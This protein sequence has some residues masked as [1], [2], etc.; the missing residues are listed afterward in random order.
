[1]TD[2]KEISNTRTCLLCSTSIDSKQK[3]Y[4][5]LNN[6]V[7]TCK[8]CRIEFTQKCQGRVR[9]YCSKSCQANDPKSIKTANKKRMD[10]GYLSENAKNTTKKIKEKY[11][12]DNISQLDSVKKKKASKGAIG[13]ARPEYNELIKNR[14]GVDNIS[15]LNEIKEKKR[16]KSLDKY[17]VDNVSKA[18][19]IIK[20]IETT[21]LKNY[22]V[23]TV[24][25]LP[26]N[27]LKSSEKNRYRISKI[28]RKWK[29]ELLNKFDV[30]FDFEQK[31]G[32][33]FLTDL[34]FENLRIDVNPSISHSNT[35]SY[36]HAAGI[37]TNAECSKKSHKP[38][39]R[40]YHQKR[41][42]DAEKN[43]LILL[44]Y[45]DWYDKN[46]FMNIVESKLKKTPERIYARK[47]VLKEIKQSEANRFFKENHLL[48]GSNGQSLCLGLFYGDELVHCQTYG[49]SR[50]NKSYEWEAIRSCSKLNTQI[51]GGFSKCDKY[52]FSK[53][54]PDS[55]ISYV[56]L[57]TGVGETEAMFDGWVFS[58]ITTPSAVW[59]KYMKTQNN[60]DS[61]MFIKDSAVRRISAD[62]MLGFEVGEKYPRFDHDGK[63][64]TNDFVMSSEGYMKIYDCGTKAFIYRSD[65]KSTSR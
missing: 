40:L 6:Y 60:A 56:D 62:K 26:E 48:G 30:N 2:K 25:T 28:N 20:K 39:E 14:Y 41:A 27:Q 10:A 65:D 36:P 45:F 13:F 64:I 3:K 33:L 35:I 24:L 21:M 42:L 37:C 46:I 5:G 15:Q 29:D 8:T 19:E 52:F 32:E 53:I 23:S 12:V 1:M 49:K 4:C 47:T 11:G 9:S 63:K 18:P 59:A 16:Q 57:S 38:R 51:I 31:V 58:H 50:F 34:G 17:N 55:V 61:P 7:S 22:G 44:Q 43:N 54:N